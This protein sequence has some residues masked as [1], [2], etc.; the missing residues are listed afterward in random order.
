MEKKKKKGK[1]ETLRAKTVK[2]RINNLFGIGLLVVQIR[3]W[4]AAI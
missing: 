4:E 1:R 3:S 2:K